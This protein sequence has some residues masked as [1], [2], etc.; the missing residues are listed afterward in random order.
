MFPRPNRIM[1]DA[2]RF[3]T[4]CAQARAVDPTGASVSGGAKRMGLRS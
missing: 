3:C 1:H 4:S 2:A